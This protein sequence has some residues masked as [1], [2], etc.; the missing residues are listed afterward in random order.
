MAGRYLPPTTTSCCRCPC[1]QVAPGLTG[2]GVRQVGTFYT[3]RRRTCCGTVEAQD[4]GRKAPG[5]A[6]FLAWERGLP[7]S[8]AP[9]HRPNLAS[10]HVA[11]ALALAPA[12]SLALAGAGVSYAR[13]LSPY[14]RPPTPMGLRSRDRARS[15]EGGTDR[16]TG[17]QAKEGGFKT[18]TCVY[19]L[20][21][22][23]RVPF[24][25]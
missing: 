10:P 14:H 20:G 24:H 5:E 17:K 1:S 19:S 12:L 18:D 4:P 9:G 22:E 2:P 15:E 25:D 7:G 6:G 8:Q 16:Q 3:A 23:L 21:K 13:C 11:L